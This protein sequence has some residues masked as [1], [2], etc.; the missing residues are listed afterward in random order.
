MAD[1]FRSTFHKKLAKFVSDECFDETEL[2]I[3][4]VFIQEEYS[5][6]LEEL[7][8]CV[9]GKIPESGENPEYDKAYEERQIR[10]GILALQRLAVPILT[11]KDGDY[12]LGD[13][14]EAIEEL[15]WQFN[16]RIEALQEHLSR[17]NLNYGRWLERL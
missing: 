4:D 11:S 2:R 12:Y 10:E 6:T 7:A 14:E 13:D 17:M 5:M 9:F 1:Q 16:E 8:R 3:F 15:L